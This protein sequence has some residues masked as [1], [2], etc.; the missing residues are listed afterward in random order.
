MAIKSDTKCAKKSKDRVLAD[1]SQSGRVFG[2]IRVS[3]IKQDV[4]GQR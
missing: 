3:T 4:E 2:Y 1:T